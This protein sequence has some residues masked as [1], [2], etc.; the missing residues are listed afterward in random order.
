MLSFLFFRRRNR[1]VET[2]RDS[3]TV[4]GRIFSS[5][6]YKG[7]VVVRLGI[8]VYLYNI[9]KSLNVCYLCKGIYVIDG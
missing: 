9:G 6:I 7:F 5:V 8:R 1:G 2:G 4:S 3:F